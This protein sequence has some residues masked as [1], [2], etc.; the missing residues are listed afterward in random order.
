MAQSVKFRQGTNGSV[1]ATFTDFPTLPAVFSC[2]IV[3]GDS[4]YAN[5]DNDTFRLNARALPN[6]TVNFPK[7]AINKADSLPVLVGNTTAALVPEMNDYFF[8]KAS[9]AG[10][11]DGGAA[12]SVFSALLLQ[13]GATAPVPAELENTTDA[14]M[15]FTRTS[16]GKYK[17]TASVPT[18]TAG[19]T[20]VIIGPAI[21]QS[22]VEDLTFSFE[23]AVNNTTEVVLFSKTSNAGVGAYSD[24]MLLNTFFEVRIYPS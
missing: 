3:A 5:H 4:L 13:E 9:T 14:A 24:D 18:F 1:T 23:A 16:T 2:G 10:A 15:T 21:A 20:V 19:K 8:L 11:G 17:C 22:G 12:Y 6:G 7:S